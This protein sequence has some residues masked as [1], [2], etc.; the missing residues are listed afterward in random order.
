MK[1]T[2]IV[3]G[4]IGAVLVVGGLLIGGS[5]VSTLNREGTLKVALEAKQDD[6]K[7]EMD[8]MWKTISQT[9]QVTEEQKNAL[10]EIFNG[11]AGA[12]TG[13]NKGG[14][15]ANWI[16][17]AVP[18]VDTSTFN[19]LQNIIVGKRDGFVQRQKELLDLNREHNAMFRVFPDN[20]I[21]SVFGRKETQVVIVTSDRTENA[22]HTG[23]DNDVELF[24]K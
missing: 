10:I 24:K 19:N 21:L 11:Y 18:N 6:N 13:A 23:K 1:K 2:L 14:S 22:F 15:L 17:E 16:H 9:A 8:G 3:V 7:N 20:I 4:V 12:R 5:I